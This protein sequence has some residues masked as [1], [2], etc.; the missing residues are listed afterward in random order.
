MRGVGESR[1][2]ASVS[3][4]ISEMV[5]A[6]TKVTMEHACEVIIGSIKCII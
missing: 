2:F 6:S 3:R 4:Y 5:Q 1:K